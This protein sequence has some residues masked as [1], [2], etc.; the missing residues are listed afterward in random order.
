MSS[1]K[2]YSLHIILVMW[3]AKNKSNGFIKQKLILQIVDSRN[4]PIK[5]QDIVVSPTEKVSFRTFFYTIKREVFGTRKKSF[6]NYKR[7]NLDTNNEA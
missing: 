4:W 1:S 5:T 3:C 2:L 7:W 6:S